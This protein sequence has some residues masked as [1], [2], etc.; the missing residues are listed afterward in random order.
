MSKKRGAGEGCISKRPDGSWQ[1]IITVGYSAT[2]RRVRKWVYGTT[3]REVTD[4]LTRLQNQKLDRTLTA[5]D[6]QR[7]G[8]YLDAWVENDT[9]LAPTTRKR[10]RGLIS[11]HI[12]PL[13]GGLKV[14]AITAVTVESF[15]ATLRG[16]GASPDTVLYCF[17]ILHRAFERLVEQRRIVVH[18]CAGMDRPKVERI[19]RPSLDAE[20]T[21]L[22]LQA[23]QGH[24]LEALFVLAVTT[25]LRQGELFG[26]QWDDVDLSAGVIHVRH[27]LEE[28]AGKLRL[29]PPK[30][31]AS[32]R[33]VLL[34]KMA[35]DALNGRWAM[36]IAE[37]AVG[38]P[39]VF[40]DRDGG[41]LRKSNFQRRV[42]EPLRKTAKLSDDLR[43]HDLR[44]TSASLLLKTGIHPKVVQERL[45]HSD[46]RTTLQTYSHVLQGLQS[47]AAASFDGLLGP[48]SADGGKLVVKPGATG[49]EMENAST[50]VEAS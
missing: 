35:V 28:V 22:L 33:S 19:E 5:T 9:R 45:G 20:D 46:I 21:T 13:V 2:G 4:K 44:H 36:A 32:R 29:K 34:P 16:K 41:P 40:C 8:D 26:L 3:K 38:V 11:K 24:R 49:K 14:G 15:M 30:S 25:G 10:Y 18:P 43:F 23:A 48:K 37:D 39:Y 42:W 31:K 6:S 12:N 50:E 27:S 17:S 7:L 47:G 1:A